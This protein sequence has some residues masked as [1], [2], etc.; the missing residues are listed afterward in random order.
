[1]YELVFL[2]S[3][4]QYWKVVHA[5]WQRPS[6]KDPL[7]QEPFRLSHHQPPREFEEVTIEFL[8]GQRRLGL[9]TVD[10]LSGADG[11]STKL[12]VHIGREAHEEPGQLALSQW[13]K[14]K[15]AWKRKGWLMDPLAQIQPRMTKP[16]KPAKPKSGRR[17]DLW[18]GW[19]HAM[20]D[21]GYRCI[22]EEIAQ[23]TG[24]TP[25]TIKQKH[26][27]YVREKGLIKP[28]KKHNQK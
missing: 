4:I 20:R 27:I 26:A 17:L 10:A 18:F 2:K 22:L 9:V 15:S 16:K 7:A 23:E 3:L 13:N 6:R 5:E 11:R 19:Y 14:L 21:S 25:G 12:L 1:M 8:D 28:L 24:Y